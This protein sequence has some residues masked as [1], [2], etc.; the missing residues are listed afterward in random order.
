MIKLRNREFKIKLLYN[1]DHIRK[2]AGREWCE[3][4]INIDK[5]GRIWV[6]IPFRWEYRS[7]SPKGL[8][9]LDINLKKVIVYNSRSVRR[10]DAR[11]KETL[12]LKHLA[13]DVQ[14]KHSYAW[15]RNEKWLGIIRAL[16]RRSRNIVVNR[17]RKF[18]K[19]IVLKARR[20]R[21]T[22]VLEDLEKL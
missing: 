22:I 6:A 1:M 13:E 4:I 8:I 2:F 9:S 11:F 3:V 18:A 17:S 16:H 15:R 10:I 20:T 19:Y 5:Q 12:Y 14:N 21:S 7:K